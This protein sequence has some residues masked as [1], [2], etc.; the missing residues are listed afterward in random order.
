MRV[1]KSTSN[2]KHQYAFNEYGNVVHIRDAE[3]LY[4]GKEMKYYLFSDKSYELILRSW[5]LGNKN[6]KHFSVKTEF[7]EYNGKKFKRDSI[8]ESIQHHNAKFRIINQGYFAWGE[9]KIPFK[10][11]R[12]EQRFSNSMFRADLVVELMSSERVFVEIIKTSDTSQSKENYIIKNQLPTFKIYIKENGDFIYDK[13][14]FI[15]NEE[16]ERIR[17]GYRARRAYFDE[18]QSSIKSGWSNYYKEKKGIDSDIRDLEERLR[19]KIESEERRLY[20]LYPDGEQEARDITPELRQKEKRIIEYRK[21]IFDVIGRIRTTRER[22]QRFKKSIHQSKGGINEIQRMESL[23]IQASESLEWK[24]V[25][26][27]HIREPKGK[28]RLLR[29]KYLLT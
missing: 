27:N 23:F 13:F 18:M 26:P 1:Y 24:W 19:S 7:V 16:I 10:N 11:P 17:T 29:L 4:E 15:G 6:Q 28:D 8:S 2:L 9:Y 21:K 14:D 5:E 12:I 3:K 25:E 20:H 22:I